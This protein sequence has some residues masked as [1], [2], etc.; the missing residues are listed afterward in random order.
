MQ[1]EEQ[2]LLP[3]GICEQHQNAKTKK[4]KQKC[5]GGNSV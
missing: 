2:I 5:W 3:L 1:R 4:I